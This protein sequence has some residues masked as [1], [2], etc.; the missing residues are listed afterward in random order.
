MEN[1]EKAKKRMRIPYIVTIIGTLLLLL[2]VFLPYAS[3]TEE[4]KERLLKNPEAQY[5]EEIEMTNKDAVNISLFEYIQLYT[6]AKNQGMNKNICVFVI[7]IIGI[8]A[9][10]SAITFILALCKK[11]V[12]TMI[13]N[14]LAFSVLRLIRFDFKDRGVMPNNHYNWGIVNLMGI[15]ITVVIIGME[16]W[17]LLAM[18]NYRRL[19]YANRA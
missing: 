9:G 11:P 13:F 14:V 10:L 19:E 8:F 2:M 16:I 18:K 12:V 4:Y 3:A 17:F 7:S 5:I 15:I 6:E 1:L